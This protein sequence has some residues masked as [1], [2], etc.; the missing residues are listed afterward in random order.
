MSKE[1]CVV[2]PSGNQEQL[3][4]F[5]EAWQ[6][7][8]V[9][10]WVH[11]VRGT[12]CA[13]AKNQG[14]QWAVAKGYDV[15]VVLDD[16]CYPDEIEQLDRFAEAHCRQLLPTLIDGSNDNRPYLVQSTVAGRIRGLPYRSYLQVP[17]V[18]ASMGY[19]RGVADL[20]AI[21]TLAGVQ[22]GEWMGGYYYGTYFPLCGMN[23]AFRPAQWLP[24]CQFV[25]VPRFD[26]IWMGWLWQKEA[27]RRA[28]CFSLQGPS[29]RHVR[30]SNVWRNLR[31]EAKYL[32]VNDRLWLRIATS[33]ETSYDA[34]RSLV[35]EEMRAA[36]HKV[37][38]E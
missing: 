2:V 11:V 36:E 21:Q 4:Q 26:D 27:Y 33:A 19:W 31:Q 35:E 18:A 15:V 12:S 30:Q 17:A 16:D 1:Y 20:D 29:V 3:D 7:D 37:R 10:E 32:E 13:Q 23:L 38:D 9:P 14:V 6:L 24:W 22:A 5:L 28:Y 8:P 25:D 34:L